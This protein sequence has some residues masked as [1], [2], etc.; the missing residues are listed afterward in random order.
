MRLGC[1]KSIAGVVL[2]TAAIMAAEPSQVPA[3][4]PSPLLDAQATALESE[5]G[6][7]MQK[8]LDGSS[9]PREL[10]MRIDVRLVARWLISRASESPA[11]SDAQAAAWIRCGQILDA[12]TLVE[13]ELDTGSRTPS[14]SSA[15]ALKLLHELTFKV[16][17]TS[18]PADPDNASRLIATALMA[19]LGSD[20]ADLDR[21]PQMRPAGK[22]NEPGQPPVAGPRSLEQLFTRSRELPISQ[23]LRAQLLAVSQAGL[24][25]EQDSKR[26]AEAGEF[27]AVL[28]DA[29]TLAE[30]LSANTAVE[31][32]DRVRMEAQVAQG[33]A[34]FLDP[35]TRTMGQG[36]VR[37][38]GRYRQMLLRLEGLHLSQEMVRRLGPVLAAARTDSDGGL[39][40]MSAI[41]TFAEQNA[42]LTA[43]NAGN[44]ADLPSLYAKAADEAKRRANSAREAFLDTA[45]S[46]SAS[47]SR[48]LLQ[49]NADGIRKALDA[50]DAITRMPGAV[51]TLNTRRPRPYGGIE[52][53]VQTALMAWTPESSEAARDASAQTLH[54]VVHIA[55][56][57][58][59]TNMPSALPKEDGTLQK[60][61]GGS[62]DAFYE[63]RKAAI[64]TLVNL[65]ASNQPLDDQ[66]FAPV[67]TAN[68]I[69]SGIELALRAE[70]AL[71]QAEALRRWADWGIDA[72]SLQAF[73]EPHRAVMAGAVHGFINGHKTPL[74]T[75]D[76]QRK[77]YEPVLKVLA[78]VAS[79]AGECAA[80]PAGRTG[81]LAKLITPVREP[82]YSEIRAT[83][84]GI[85]VWLQ[86]HARDEKS[87]DATLASLAERLPK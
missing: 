7:M 78:A 26:Q 70:Q 17:E 63:A 2:Y 5:I 82:S 50:L 28:D 68:A 9:V 56:L 83:R 75:W 10:E 43:L 62:L 32:D 39:K 31:R 20:A 85:D 36:R 47:K 21:L 69:L 23:P 67:E 44:S 30:G 1:L 53:R 34:M 76:V 87:A 37:A 81:A 25:A 51:K 64:L 84:F 8:R 48:G 73:F 65:A 19:T 16:L 46:S 35:R 55:E 66:A 27:R 80:L 41:E 74:D 52:K 6:R 59:L 40:L 3:F 86:F 45:S 33:L 38:L 14:A 54:Y 79:R 11:G 12:A 15:A 58:E 72:E 22:T 4:N 29:V 42:R 57:V 61:T 60:Y 18:K 24:A 77:R 49:E 13:R 71:A